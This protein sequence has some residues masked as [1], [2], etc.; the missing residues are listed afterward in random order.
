MLYKFTIYQK[1]IIES[2]RYYQSKVSRCRPA[3]ISPQVQEMKNLKSLQNQ[4]KNYGN[5]FLLILRQ[6][7][8]SNSRFHN[9]K[10]VI[11]SLK[12]SKNDPI[13][14]LWWL[15]SET[16]MYRLPENKFI[17]SLRQDRF[18]NLTR[19]VLEPTP[20]FFYFKNS[21]IFT[22]IQQKRPCQT[23]VV[24]RFRDTHAPT[25]RKYVSTEPKTRL[26][27]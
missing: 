16:R 24:A 9:S 19:K 1:S 3:A 4:K 21:N 22:Q 7:H 5:I 14:H 20:S 26:L 2:R 12:F 6:D 17:L 27:Q 13:R 8:F 11:F 10:T 18:S 25:S 15:V 23:L